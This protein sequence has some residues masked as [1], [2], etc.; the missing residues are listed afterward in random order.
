[1]PER[2]RDSLT[3]DGEGEGRLA[4]IRRTTTSLM[5]GH[6]HACPSGIRDDG[7]DVIPR[8]PARIHG[9]MRSRAQRTHRIS[10]LRQA[11]SGDSI[12]TRQRLVDHCIAC[13]P[14]QTLGQGDNRGQSMADRVVEFGRHPGLSNRQVSLS[15]HCR[16]P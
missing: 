1:M 8:V 14:G 2:V 4:R 13:F 9:G 15:L 12:D 3:R 16:S 7:M 6:R 11:F 10:R 5:E